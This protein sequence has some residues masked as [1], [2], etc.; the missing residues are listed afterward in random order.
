MTTR[1]S[2]EIRNSRSSCALDRRPS[3]GSSIAATKRE[4]TRPLVFIR[5]LCPTV[6]LSVSL[7]SARARD[8]SP[9][10]SRRTRVRARGHA[11]HPDDPG[12]SVPSPR[13]KDKR[14]PASGWT[15]PVLGSRKR[16]ATIA[17]KIGADPRLPSDVFLAPL[18]YRLK[19]RPL[20]DRTLNATVQ[21][22]WL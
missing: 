3:R 5:V 10:S 15:G 9:T 21:V 4:R 12:P 18:F 11:Q 13:P 2:S 7:S 19:N 16:S 14:D 20:D 17:M 1:E 22:S 8:A 6:S